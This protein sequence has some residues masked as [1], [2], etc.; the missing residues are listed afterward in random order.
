ML[1]I[2]VLFSIAT[3]WLIAIPGKSFG[4]NDIKS[5][6]NYFI[7][8]KI[9]QEIIPAIKEI[10]INKNISPYNITFVSAESFDFIK[11][12]EAPTFVGRYHLKRAH[13]LNN[14]NYYQIPNFDIWILKQKNYP[15]IG[16]SFRNDQNDKITFEYD[17]FVI[18]VDKRST[19]KTS[20]YLQLDRKANPLSFKGI[21]FECHA[22][23]P[24]AIRPKESVLAKITTEGFNR[25]SK[26]NSIISNYG[27]METYVPKQ[28]LKIPFPVYKKVQHFKYLSPVLNEPLK[29]KS[30]ISCHNNKIRKEL[31]RQHRYSIEFLINNGPIN[32][33]NDQAKSSYSNFKTNKAHMPLY[34]NISEA[35]ISCIDSWIFE[36]NIDGCD[37]LGNPIQINPFD[38]GNWIVTSKSNI[39]VDVTTSAFPFSLKNIDVSGRV[40]C[41]KYCSLKIN[42]DLYHASTDN[43]TRDDKLHKLIKNSVVE[44]IVEKFKPNQVNLEA[45]IKISNQQINTTIP[46]KCIRDNNTN[47]KITCHID[48]IPLQL[49]QFGISAPK[50][51][52]IKVDDTVNIS[53]EIFLQ[54]L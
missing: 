13:M 30:C 2:K 42:F 39:L 36:K 16:M 44:V 31:L 32:K 43:D 35:E 21:C 54:K 47:D 20:Y 14:I 52:F 22:N 37:K 40:K 3:I 6:F 12:Q 4:G 25:I 29:A 9:E 1:N 5:D 28:N 15:Q 38:T 23:G 49:S 7:P 45:K 48:K 46:V 18:A 27:V 51:L 24:R 26:I 11:S 41:K 33:K 8:N 19:L 50:F 34:N 17:T 10:I 53:G